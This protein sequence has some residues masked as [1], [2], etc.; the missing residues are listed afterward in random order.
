MIDEIRFR[1]PK[2]DPQSELL[3]SELQLL[4]FK[5]KLCRWH[6]T[7]DKGESYYET[8]CG[9]AQFFVKG[10]TEKCPICKR[11]IVLIDT[12]GAQK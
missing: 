9:G 2:N 10:E 3:K 7:K 11:T 8:E 6:K 12:I 1:F 4:A 5:S